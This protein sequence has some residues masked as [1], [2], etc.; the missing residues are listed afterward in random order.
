MA[1]PAGES[2]LSGQRLHVA[3][4][5]TGPQAKENTDCSNAIVARGRR[6]FTHFVEGPGPDV[7]LKEVKELRGGILT[8]PTI[9]ELHEQVRGDVITPEHDGYN[10]ARTVYNAMIDKHPR[11]VVRA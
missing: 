5:I 10:E 8:K 9:D 3:V 1:L 6:E 2:S 11:V 4:G 7:W